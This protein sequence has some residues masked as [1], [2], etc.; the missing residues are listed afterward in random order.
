MNIHHINKCMTDIYNLILDTTIFN[1]KN[2]IY[3]TPCFLLLQKEKS[4]STYHHYRQNHKILYTHF[5]N[6]VLY[7]KNNN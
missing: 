3:Y 5:S 1:W 6:Q 4:C 2:A 7:M